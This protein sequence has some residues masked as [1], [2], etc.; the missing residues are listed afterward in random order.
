MYISGICRLKIAPQTTSPLADAP[1]DSTEEICHRSACIPSKDEIYRLPAHVPPTIKLGLFFRFRSRN[2]DFALQYTLANLVHLCDVV[3]NKAE[4]VVGL[5]RVDEQVSAFS[6]LKEARDALVSVAESDSFDEK[7]VDG[8]EVLMRPLNA[9]FCVVCELRTVLC[10]NE[11]A[12][13]P[14]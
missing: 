10:R 13:N 1:S 12:T 7:I 3:L 4:S 9:F 8:Q 5:V 6:P 11:E 14:P 2:I